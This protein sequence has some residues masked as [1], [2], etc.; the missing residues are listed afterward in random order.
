MT[1]Y[2][3]ASGGQVWWVPAPA[4]PPTV[5]KV[6]AFDILARV[7]HAWAFRFGPS[8]KKSQFL[9][10]GLVV[11]G[12]GKSADCTLGQGAMHIPRGCT[13]GICLREP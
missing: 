4:R 13:L 8:L 6:L 1:Q 3:I 2:L 7:L 11:E 5:S 10:L 12:I 9:H